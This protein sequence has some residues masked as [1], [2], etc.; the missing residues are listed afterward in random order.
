MAAII[1][2]TEMPENCRECPMHDASTHC[3]PCVLW[4]GIPAHQTSEIERPFWCP[5]IEIKNPDERISD[6]DGQIN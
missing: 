5:L 1:G 4:D 2:I 6:A 3:V